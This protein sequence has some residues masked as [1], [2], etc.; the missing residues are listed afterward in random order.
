MPTSMPSR[1]LDSSLV[2]N[3]QRM[4][5]STEGM[6]VTMEKTGSSVL[7]TA[8]LVCSSEPMSEKRLPSLA[9]E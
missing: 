3:L 4:T 7:P 9:T 2:R 5:M 6:D 8:L 1:K